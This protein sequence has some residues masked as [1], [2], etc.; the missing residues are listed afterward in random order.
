MTGRTRLSAK[1]RGHGPGGLRAMVVPGSL[2]EEG[3]ANTAAVDLLGLAVGVDEGGERRH[4]FE[5]DKFFMRHKIDIY[6][7]KEF[8]LAHKIRY[9]P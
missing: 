7:I 4:V 1:T 3:F 6:D 8:V 2:G 5:A 9:V